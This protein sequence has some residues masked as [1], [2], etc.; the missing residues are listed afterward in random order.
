[1]TDDGHDHEEA[2]G[3][4]ARETAPQSEFTT[5]QAGLGFVVLAVGLLVVFGIPL[6]LV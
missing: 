5:R 6:L 1:M 2:T 4:W 3:I